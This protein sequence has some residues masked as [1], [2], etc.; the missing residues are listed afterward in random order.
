MGLCDVFYRET[1]PDE[2][3]S[4]LDRVFADFRKGQAT[5]SAGKDFMGMVKYGKSFS[6]MLDVP[7]HR[8]LFQ[9]WA[10]SRG[11]TLEM[12]SQ[13]LSNPE[14]PP[15][16]PETS[17]AEI[18]DITDLKRLMITGE[19]VMDVKEAP[20]NDFVNIWFEFSYANQK[21][22]TLRI[23]IFRPGLNEGTGYICLNEIQGEKIGEDNIKLLK[24]RFRIHPFEAAMALLIR[25]VDNLK[26]YRWQIITSVDQFS[27]V[28]GKKFFQENAM[29]SPSGEKMVL[30]SDS[31]ESWAGV[32]SPGNSRFVA[33]DR[34]KKA[35]K[36]ALAE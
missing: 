4:Y 6:L 30:I 8:E 36:R 17:P 22:L 20:S 32:S 15:P 33:L 9:S 28:L 26:N 11:F 16:V 23:H 31:P 12:A 21:I 7:A 5:S 35:V 29:I 10:D 3:F 24:K 1:D 2:V 34:N 19:C 13:Y 18:A 14:Q 27:R 25:S